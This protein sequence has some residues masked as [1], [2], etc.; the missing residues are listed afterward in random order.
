MTVIAYTKGVLAGD[1]CWSE[2]S[3][4][5]ANVQNKLVRFPSGAIYG[6]AGACDDRAMQTLLRNVAHP[7]R[8]PDG[9]TLSSDIYAAVECL[10][11]LP[12]KSVWMIA[13]GPEGY[14]VCPLQVKYTAIGAGQQLAI[15]AMAA[16][17]SAVDAVKIACQWNALCRTPVH[18]LT[19][20]G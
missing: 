2:E 17:A 13:G 18:K 11:V 15:G 16:G 3:G 14:G 8:L 1:S 9:N 20:K 12:D 5:I 6:G 10:L 4:L 7:E 19:L